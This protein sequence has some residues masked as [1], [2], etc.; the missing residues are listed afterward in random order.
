MIVCPFFISF[1]FNSF[2]VD[3]DISNSIHMQK[4]KKINMLQDNLINV[5]CQL[6][7]VQARAG[8]YRQV[9]GKAAPAGSMKFFRHC[10]FRTDYSKG[11]KS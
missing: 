6:T 7:S 10:T 4:L 9:L 8:R 5:I 1:H 3:S 2:N 11:F